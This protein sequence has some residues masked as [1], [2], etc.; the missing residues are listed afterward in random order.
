MLTTPDHSDAAT[1]LP[2]MEPVG[3]KP[4]G[5]W[6]DCDP[7][8]G[9]AGTRFRAE[10]FNEAAINLR[11]FLAAAGVA[12]VKGAPDMLLASLNRLFAGKVTAV[13]ATGALT[14]DNAGLVIVDATTADVT[15]TLPAAAVL[16][17]GSPAFSFVRLDA[18]THRVRIAPAAGDVIRTGVLYLE[19]E[20]ALL[21]SDGVAT[22]WSLTHGGAPITRAVTLNVAPTGVANPADPMGGDA[23]N[24]LAAALDWLNRRAIIQPG[25]VTIQIAA[26]TYTR[27]TGIAFDHPNGDRIYVA[28]AGSAATV[29]QFNA[30]A[31]GF[32][33]RGDLAGLSKL[34]LRGDGTMAA[35]GSY[36]IAIPNSLVAIADDV[37]IDNFAGYGI[38]LAG[39]LSVGSLTGPPNI[40]TI[41]NCGDTGMRVQPNG[42]LVV[43][44]V[45]ALVLTNNGPANANLYV[46]SGGVARITKL[47]TTGGGRGV[48]LQNRASALIG[49][50]T[51]IDA[52]PTAEAVRVENG[53]FLGIDPL[54]VGPW[55]ARNAASSVFHVFY[56]LEMG[57]IDAR[58]Q[59][60]ASCKA[61]ANPAINTVGNHQAYILTW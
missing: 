57:Q 44:S 50:L 15:L 55:V 48:W 25:A 34:T 8:T 32:Y 29:L 26:G 54:S 16:P 5:F 11:R 36:G 33:M 24:E 51:V 31:I 28:G 38:H 21:R 43:F 17:A 40:L 6:L 12:P 27:T 46:D 35:A 7:A 41:Q 37:V 58:D 60:H 22:W 42:G 10:E 4:S 56:A 23:F 1:A 9:A 19:T 49:Q 39:N 45:G 14:A 52:T 20:P 61:L 3:P 13:V 18:T 2:A 59:M 47:T 30:G 53:S